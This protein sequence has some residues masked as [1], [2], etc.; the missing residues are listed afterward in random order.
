MAKIVSY[1]NSSV[2][3]R[4]SGYHLIT[5]IQNAAFPTME[6]NPDVIKSISR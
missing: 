1:M 2:L 5:I 3:K 6:M 4:T